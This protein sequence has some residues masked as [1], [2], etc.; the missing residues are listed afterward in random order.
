MNK[1]RF[2]ILVKMPAIAAVLLFSV[3]SSAATVYVTNYGADGS[4]NEAGA[5]ANVTAFQNAATAAG[6]GGTIIVP[7]GVYYIDGELSWNDI[8]NLT[9]MAED[10][11]GAT[12]KRVST[13]TDPLSLIYPRNGYIIEGLTFD[14]NRGSNEP[15]D[16][17]GIRVDWGDNV[18]IRECTIKNNP[19]DGILVSSDRYGLTVEGCTVINNYRMGIAITNANHGC[20]INDTYFTGNAGGGLDFEPDFRHTGNHSVARCTFDNDTFNA[21]GASYFPWNITVDDCNFINN[22][23]L[24]S[25]R[26]MN[27]TARGNTFSGGSTVC[28]NAAHTIDEGAGKISLSG[29]I[30][31]S[32]NGVNLLANGGFELWTSGE[33]D[34][35]TAGSG[36]TIEQAPAKHALGG[37]SAAHL[38]LSGAG[39]VYLEQSVGVS[40]EEY[41]TFGGYVCG[42]GGRSYVNLYDPI[43]SLEFLNG[44]SSVLKTV[45]LHI[46]YDYLAYKYY[47]KVMAVAQAPAG[48]VT[49]RVRVRCNSGGDAEE[50]FFDEM[51]LY[52]GVYQGEDLT[53]EQVIYRFDFEPVYGSTPQN[54]RFTMPDS[55][56]IDPTM[57]YDVNVGYGFDFGDPAALISR[58]RS[59]TLS[60]DLRAFDMVIADSEAGTVTDNDNFAVDLPNGRYFV[61][62]AGGDVAYDTWQRLRIEGVIYRFDPL[63]TGVIEPN[64]APLYIFDV[65]ENYEVKEITPDR[66]GAYGN[67]KCWGYNEFFPER[68]LLYLQRGIVEVT[69]GQLNVQNFA[70]GPK[71]YNFLEIAPVPIEVCADIVAAGLNYTADL[72]DDCDVD[73]EDLALM[74]ELWAQCNYPG[75]DGCL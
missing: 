30:G 16:S 12:V 26:A 9:V 36:G 11:N 71:Q 17:Y 25:T 68:E 31:L 57:L 35:W 21:Y 24:Y 3:L 55:I 73:M 54:S 42:D 20:V 1:S 38:S 7:E 27:I 62:F 75:G 34:G 8:F 4:G 45:N 18:T 33:P 43:I 5:S 47:E 10:A 2:G 72:D 58:A 28:F 50:G 14:G 37:S 63:Q 67:I 52:Q 41:Y 19:F 51:F 48:A 70:N 39:A 66:Q 32:S 59:A 74:L 15:A 61:S 23:V 65:G 44:S 46:W 13:G 53:A 56:H 60:D 29:N 22:S 69:D 6:T 64:G 40:A 49:A